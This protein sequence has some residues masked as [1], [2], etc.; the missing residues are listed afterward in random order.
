MCIVLY[1]ERFERERGRE[2]GSFP[3]V[4]V[5]KP[6]GVRKFRLRNFVQFPPPP[7]IKNTI[8]SGVFNSFHFLQYSHR[9]VLLLDRYT[10]HILVRG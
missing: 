1:S 6:Q 10:A 7:Q 3:V 4:E 5:L 8:H 2:N 9:T